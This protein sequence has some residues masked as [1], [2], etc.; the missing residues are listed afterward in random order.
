MRTLAPTDLDYFSTAPLRITATAPLAAS[1]DAVFAA[2]ADASEWVRWF[3]L[4]HRAAWTHGDAGVGAE[5]EVAL[6]GLGRF[7]ERIIAWEPGARFAFTMVGTTSPMAR[8]MAEDYRLTAVDGGTRLDWVMAATPT[9]LGRVAQPALR[10][11]VRRMLL[12]AA[13]R[14]DRYLVAPR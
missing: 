2:L 6:R 13:R 5:R 3:P 7:A 10:A 11:I 12:R 9:G 4:M 8:Q 14:L 1:P